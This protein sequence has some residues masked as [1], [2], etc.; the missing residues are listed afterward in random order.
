MPFDK[1][2]FVSYIKSRK[3]YN[4]LTSLSN[5]FREINKD[6]IYYLNPGG[7]NLNLSANPNHNFV[8][9]VDGTTE[10]RI[11]AN[12]FNVNTGNDTPQRSIIIL[13]DT[14]TFT[15]SIQK[16]YGIFI[17]QSAINTGVA[18]LGLKIKGNLITANLNNQRTQNAINNE[19]P[20]VFIVFDTQTYLDLLPFIT[21]A[22]YDWKQLQ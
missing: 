20:S 17:G 9:V 5:D 8:L 3:E 16:A 19:R 10:V 4:V 21:V 22:K 2:H 11:T 13:A 6:G 12:N 14:I 7:G 1:D 15:P 18:D